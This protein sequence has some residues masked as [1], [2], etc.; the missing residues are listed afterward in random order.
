MPKS[1]ELKQAVGVLKRHMGSKADLIDAA[2]GLPDVV[3]GD[4]E[5][6]QAIKKAAKNPAQWFSKVIRDL[7]DSESEVYGF[8]PVEPYTIKDDDVEYSGDAISFVN[9]SGAKLFFTR[10][11][12]AARIEPIQGKIKPEHLSPSPYNPRQA[13]RIAT[14]SSSDE[15]PL[16]LQLFQTLTEAGVEAKEANETVTTLLSE[17]EEEPQQPLRTFIKTKLKTQLP[18]RTNVQVRSTYQ[19][20]EANKLKTTVSYPNSR[21]N[22]KVF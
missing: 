8:V 12:V 18:L 2:L 11:S 1:Y 7:N 9:D 10:G 6:Q 15:R 21:R 16:P 14:A 3:S 17:S 22:S 5:Q 20:R 19:Q 13:T 4:K